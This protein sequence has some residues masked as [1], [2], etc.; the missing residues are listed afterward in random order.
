MHL[1]QFTMRTLLS[2]LVLTPVTWAVQAQ[3]AQAQPQSGVDRVAVR[4][5][6]NVLI[7]KEGDLKKNALGAARVQQ[8]SASPNSSLK[9]VAVPAGTTLTANL[10][11]L[12]KNESAGTSTLRPISDAR[13]EVWAFAPRAFGIWSWAKE[14]TVL[15]TSSGRMTAYMP[16]RQN[17]IV[18]ALR[19]FATNSAVVVWPDQVGSTMPFYKEP[20]QP[21]G[22][23]IK[24]TVRS[25]GETLDFSYDF[26]DDFSAKHYNVAE[27][28]RWARSYAL[29]NRGDTDYLPRA[30]FQ[31]GGPGSYY[32]PANDTVNLMGNH[33]FEDATIL[34]EYAHFIQEQVGDLPWVATRHDGCLATEVLTGVPVADPRWA[35]MEAFAN[36][37]AEV[38]RRTYPSAGLSSGGHTLPAWI[39]ET[40]RCTSSAPGDGVEVRV[41]GVL[42]DTFDTSPGDAYAVTEGS[43]V[44]LRRDK[45]VFQIMDNELDDSRGGAT[46][47]RFRSAW[48]ARALNVPQLDAVF[49]L[50]GVPVR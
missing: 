46:I 23:A 12:D 16:Y 41:A 7:V 33:A 21:D 11:Y 29:S 24:R 43:D 3:T 39:M 10:R 35:W 15:T 34:H 38:V 22:A 6:D 2:A 40:P 19:V 50:N 5:A 8:G 27:T 37:Y 49:R 32:N 17:G 30:S 18:Y 9:Q 42:W 25:P 28:S 45:A 13:V 4:S 31:L 44:L 26:R 36:Y 14:H 20:G 1:K 47:S 48:Q